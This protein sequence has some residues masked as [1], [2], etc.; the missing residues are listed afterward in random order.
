V[1][2]LISNWQSI[3]QFQ[4]PYDTNAQGTTYDNSIDTGKTR[5]SKYPYLKQKAAS[6]SGPKKVGSGLF[7]INVTV[8][9]G[10]Q[11][12]MWPWTGYGY[13]NRAVVS[14]IELS[15][16][17]FKN[18]T[19]N[20][21]SN[22]FDD[23]IQSRLVIP[24]QMAVNIATLGY[25]YAQT[26]NPSWETARLAITSPQTVPI[27]SS[28][29]ST[30]WTLVKNSGTTLLNGGTA[31]YSSLATLT[32]WSNL[33]VSVDCTANGPFNLLLQTSSGV[34]LESVLYNSVFGLDNFLTRVVSVNIPVYSSDYYLGSEVEFQIQVDPSAPAGT[35]VNV[36]SVT[37]VNYPISQAT[38]LT[39]AASFT[40]TSQR[41][42]TGSG[43]NGGDTTVQNSSGSSSSSLSVGAIVGVVIGAVVFLLMGAAAGYVVSTRKH[44][45]YTKNMVA[46]ASHSEMTKTREPAFTI[47]P[48]HQT[49]HDTAAV[50]AMPPPPAFYA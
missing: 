29:T 38:T 36:I 39:G 6:S 1:D 20:S 47:S 12:A 14:G 34:L 49:Q 48:I 15:S 24:N 5:S 2:R 43:S 37:A 3:N 16:F 40:W 26:W 8:G 28:I 11:D 46:M 25:R 13:T 21:T 19:K 17:S 31:T 50:V 7:P 35:T 42:S 32:A 33:T 44:S 10:G 22:L 41:L 30:G 27:T 45:Q 9:H 18:G 23:I 4:I